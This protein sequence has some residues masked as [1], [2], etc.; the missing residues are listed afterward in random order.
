AIGTE[1]LQNKA[2][3]QIQYYKSQYLEQQRTGQPQPGGDAGE[4]IDQL[5]QAQNLQN[6]IDGLN[7]KGSNGQGLTR[8]EANRLAQL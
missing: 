1:V 2:M 3:E 6:Q 8:A 5:N 7:A 4:L